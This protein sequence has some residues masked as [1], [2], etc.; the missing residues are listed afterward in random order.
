MPQRDRV[1]LIRSMSRQH[2]LLEPSNPCIDMVKHP[3]FQQVAGDLVTRQ[4]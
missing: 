3:A 1:A 4:S 2:Y